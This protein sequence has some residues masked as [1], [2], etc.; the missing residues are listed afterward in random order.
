MSEETSTILEPLSSEVSQ[1][2]PSQARLKKMESSNNQQDQQPDKKK[3]K[4]PQSSKVGVLMHTR[5]QN[6]QPET[7]MMLLRAPPASS[8][9]ASSSSA[10]TAAAAAEAAIPKRRFIW[11]ATEDTCINDPLKKPTPAEV[12][13]TWRPFTP[14]LPEERVTQLLAIFKGRERAS[15]GRAKFE[16]LL[17]EAARAYHPSEAALNA[18]SDK[19]LERQVKADSGRLSVLFFFERLKLD[20]RDRLVQ[21]MLLATGPEVDEILGE[22]DDIDLDLTR[23]NVRMVDSVASAELGKAILKRR[24]INVAFKCDQATCFNFGKFE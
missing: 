14:H 15:G 10:A 13:S 18:L 24:G 11:Q 23:S 9:E 8:E 21:K 12:R 1:A 5:V 19:D 6:G 4:K 17:G 22:I 2:K 7:V 20:T 16:E 3:K